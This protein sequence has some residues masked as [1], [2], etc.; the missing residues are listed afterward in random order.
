MGDADII[1][2]AAVKSLT[3]TWHSRRSASR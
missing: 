2:N 3:A 1:F